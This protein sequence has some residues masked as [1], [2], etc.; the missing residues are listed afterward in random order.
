MKYFIWILLAAVVLFALSTTE[1]VRK[2]MGNYFPDI[3]TRA[4][5]SGKSKQGSGGESGDKPTGDALPVVR[6]TERRPDGSARPK[7]MMVDKAK[8]V[9]GWLSEDT[10]E[11][12]VMRADGKARFAMAFRYEGELNEEKDFQITM[13]C[14][15]FADW[16]IN[17]EGFL[18]FKNFRFEKSEFKDFKAARSGNDRHRT[19]SAWG[20]DISSFKNEEGKLLREMNEWV[21][22]NR[23]G[24]T[25]TAM[26]ANLMVTEYNSGPVT[27]EKVNPYHVKDPTGEFSPV[28]QIDKDGKILG[29]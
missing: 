4:D 25:I 21:S 15:G 5:Y 11:F 28:F 27:Y 13:S 7:P 16:Q 8:L 22:K 29:R 19:W 2:L 12:I 3:L 6:L 20:Y 24:C 17:N 14:V 1:P 9:G 23:L 10:N 26:D 18:E